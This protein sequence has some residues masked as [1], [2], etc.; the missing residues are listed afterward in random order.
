MQREKENRT[1]GIGR[2]ACC[3]PHRILLKLEQPLRVA[4]QDLGLVLAAE[5]H[6]FHPLRAG[7]VRYEGVVYG[8]Q[9]AIDAHLHDAAEQ[10]WRREVAPRGD[11]E[12]LAEGVAKRS[13]AIALARERHV[14]A[15]QRERERLAEV[16]ENDLEPRI[17]L[18]H[19]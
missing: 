7:G 8:E 1:A 16:A 5:R 4:V 11:P 12:M 10:G 9:D 6:G 2:Y 13:L 18:E 14:D 15:P 3:S 19:A 17:G